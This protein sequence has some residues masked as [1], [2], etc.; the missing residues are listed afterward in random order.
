MASS[1]RPAPLPAAAAYLLSLSGNVDLVWWAFPIAEVVSLIFTLIFFVRI[2][3]RK[4]MPLFG[5]I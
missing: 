4:V 3:R 1:F 2:Y 5:S